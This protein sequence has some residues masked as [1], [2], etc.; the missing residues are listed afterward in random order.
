MNTDNSKVALNTTQTKILPENV[1]DILNRVRSQLSEKS[2]K[3]KK[4]I[5]KPSLDKAESSVKEIK[6]L[7]DGDLLGD[8]T[9]KNK[10][11]EK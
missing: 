4:S 7:R 11:P 9:K 3:A 8:T 2:V 10:I 6:S 5:I 1:D